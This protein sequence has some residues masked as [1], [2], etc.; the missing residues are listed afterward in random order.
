MVGNFGK[1]IGMSLAIAGIAFMGTGCPAGG[2]SV[3]EIWLVNDSDEFEITSVV[4]T[5]DSDASQSEEL[6][7][8]NIPPNTTR[9]VL[10]ATVE[11]FTGSTAT[12]DISGFSIA[13]S[14][15]IDEA[16][17]NGGVYPIVIK[18]DTALTFDAEYLPIVNGS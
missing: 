15:Q 9:R 4:I 11:S 13:T 14:V 5:N 8:G 10:L 16:I 2:G 18:G 1:I 7:S 6:V 3:I 12:L 17:A